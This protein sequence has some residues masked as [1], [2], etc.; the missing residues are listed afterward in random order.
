MRKLLL[1]TIILLTLTSCGGKKITLVNLYRAQ[2]YQWQKNTL[3]IKVHWNIERPD[4]NTIIADGYV[5][6]FT[7]ATGLHHVRLELVG[8]DANG[9]AVN[10][11]YGIPKDTRIVSPISTSPFRLTMKL[12]G[13]EDDFTMR[14]GYYH[15]DAGAREDMDLRSYDTIPLKSDEPY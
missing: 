11:V 14:G 7:P 6:P 2:D 13:K 15:F 3:Y 1:L 8:L 12:N 4:A 5:E 9:I 10:S